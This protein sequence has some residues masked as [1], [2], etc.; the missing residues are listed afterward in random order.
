MNASQRLVSTPM[1][2]A[3]GGED[4]DAAVSSSVG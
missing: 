4:D 3:F 2:G 1:A